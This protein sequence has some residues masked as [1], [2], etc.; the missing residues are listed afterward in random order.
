MFRTSIATVSLSGDLAEKLGAI[1]RAGFD[2]V[3]IFENDFLA[4]PAGPSEVGRIARETGLKVTV[5]QPF[6]DFEGL[7]EPQRSR[8]FERAER[9]FDVMQALG[10]DLMLVCSSVSPA[11]LGGIDRAA[12]DFRELGERAAERGLRIGYEALAWG[13]HISDH[14][15]AWEVVR[16]ASHPAIGLILDSFHTLARDL[17][18]DTIRRIPGDRIFLVQVADAPLVEM[19]LLS[20]SR[21]FRTMPGQGGLDIAGFLLAVEATGYDGYLSLEIFNDQFRAGSARQVAVDGRRSLI[22]AMDQVACHSKSVASGTEA[23]PER[24]L[25]LAV[26]FM[27]FAIDEEGAAELARLFAALGFEQAGRHLS[28]DVEWWRQGAINLVINSQREGLAHSSYITH[29]PSVCA[30][31]LKVGDAEAAMKRAHAL[32]AQP[33]SQP[34]GPGELEVPAIRGVGGSL[35]YF[36]DP[37]SEL[38]RI[39]EIEFRP[40]HRFQQDLAQEDAELIA[41]DHISQSMEYDEMLS[42]VLFYTSILEMDRTPQ[43]DVADPAGLVR[44]QV[45]QSRNGAVRI[46]LNGTQSHRTLSGRFLTEFFGSGVQHIAFASADIYRSARTLYANGVKL[47][48]IPE[49]YYD[50]LESR[51]ALDPKFVERLKSAGLLYDRDEGGEYL[52]LYTD[53]FDERFFFEIVQRVGGYRGFGAANAPIRLAAQSRTSRRPELEGI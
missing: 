48:A 35:L 2:G 5:F 49:N 33:F 37:Q 24:A 21:H 20:W 10:T 45:V 43:L 16:R 51:F 44:S 42:W 50:D 14:R 1:A 53:A 36:T 30:I 39:W 25:L 9:K 3:E 4:Y 31:G 26:E 18:P 19:D 11:A 27:E 47:L 32:L 28:K 38:A 7:P 15:D 29:G 22:Y 13:R 46:A 17:D 6:R 41:V 8:A 12:A 23:L 52:Q 34:V 40:A